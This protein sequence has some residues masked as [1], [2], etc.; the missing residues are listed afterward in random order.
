[1]IMKYKHYLLLFNT[2][3]M[4]ISNTIIPPQKKKNILDPFYD[5]QAKR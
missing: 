5:I 4:H 2:L 3:R 1:M